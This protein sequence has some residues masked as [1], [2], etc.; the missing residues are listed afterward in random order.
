MVEGGSGGREDGVGVARCPQNYQ[1]DPKSGFWGVALIVWNQSYEVL[2]ALLRL[3]VRAGARFEKTLN[4]C[5]FERAGQKL[6]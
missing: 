1:R 6:D 3:R 2:S 5:A 4:A